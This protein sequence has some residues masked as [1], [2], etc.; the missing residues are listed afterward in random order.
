L[1]RFG[2]FAFSN[3][4]DINLVTVR[5]QSFLAPIEVSGIISRGA[6][7]ADNRNNNSQ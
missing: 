5:N 2:I 4:P 7:Y 6:G 3:T 1:A